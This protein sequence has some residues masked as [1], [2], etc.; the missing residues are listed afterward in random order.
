MAREVWRYIPLQA[1]SGAFHMAADD[2]FASK[3]DLPNPVFRLYTWNPYAI[4]LG[5]H[6]SADDIQFEL[7]DKEGIDVVRRPTGGRAILHAEEITYSLILPLDHPYAQGGIHDVHNKISE[8]I[9]LG[10]KDLG[11]RLTLN[12]QEFNLSQHYRKNPDSVACFSTTTEHELQYQGK[13]VV[14]SAQK[15]YSK[16]LLQHGSIL[17]GDKHRDLYR[18][19]SYSG[20]KLTRFREILDKKTAEL[21]VSSINE[22]RIEA[23]LING[24]SEYFQ[25]KFKQGGLLKPESSEIEFNSVK[26]RVRKNEIAQ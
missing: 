15:R 1:G 16:N 17:L 21:P 24:F 3:P 26:F 13:K 23:A 5:Y 12:K 20:N 4:S 19:L 18:Y 9:L 10:F 2:Y 7:C 8:A 6:Q 22:D 11:I 25:T 14:G